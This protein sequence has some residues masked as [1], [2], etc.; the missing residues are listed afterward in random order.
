M[1]IK[2]YLPD[3][4]INFCI[5]LYTLYHVENYGDS[6][7]MPCNNDFWVFNIQSMGGTEDLNFL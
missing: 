1:T 5:F 3:L 6:F 4:Q 2:G 7:L